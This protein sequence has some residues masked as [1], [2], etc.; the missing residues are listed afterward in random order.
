[1]SKNACQVELNYFKV[2]LYKFK[3]SN[4]SSIADSV[5]GI[6]LQEYNRLENYLA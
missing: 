5:K 1:M 3:I 2:L 6:R 4:I